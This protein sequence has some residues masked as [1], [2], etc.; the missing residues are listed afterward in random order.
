MLHAGAGKNIKS[1]VEQGMQDANAKTRTKTD[2]TFDKAAA[3]GQDAYRSAADKGANLAQ[4]TANKL[5]TSK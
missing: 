1:D 2:S 5:D 4:N 3:Q